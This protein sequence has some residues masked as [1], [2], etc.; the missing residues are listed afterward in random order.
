MKSKMKRKRHA[1]MSIVR[2]M[3]TKISSLKLTVQQTCRAKW[4]QTRFKSKKT[5]TC[6]R[7]IKPLLGPTT[8][9]TWKKTNVVKRAKTMKQ[10]VPKSKHRLKRK[11][12]KSLLNAIRT[13]IKTQIKQKIRKWSLKISSI[14]TKNTLSKRT[15]LS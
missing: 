8:T 7:M 13:P 15:R 14:S 6:L 3:L 4:P 10:I 2:L 9:K 12:R 1:M 5:S 11:Q